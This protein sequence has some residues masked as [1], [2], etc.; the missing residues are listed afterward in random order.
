MFYCSQWDKMM[1]KILMKKRSKPKILMITILCVAA[2]IAFPLSV[3][4]HT[5]GWIDSCEERYENN[6]RIYE[7]FN[8]DDNTLAFY[9]LF[10]ES[11]FSEYTPI[12][13]LCIVDDIVELADSIVALITDD[14]AK[15]KAISDW[16]SSNVWYDYD[17]FNSGA[18][19]V[20]SPFTSYTL[21]H[22]RTHCEGYSNLTVALLRALG[23]PARQIRGENLEMGHVWVA[24]FVDERWILIDPTWNSLNYFENGQYSSQRSAMDKFFDISLKELSESHTFLDWPEYYMI[25]G[26]IL[27]H[28]SDKTLYAEVFDRDTTIE[29]TIPES[30]RVLSYKY[31]H[32]LRLTSAAED[33]F[34]PFNSLERL[35]MSDNLIYLNTNIFMYSPLSTIIFSTNLEELGAYVFIGCENLVEVNLPESIN[36]IGKMAFA[37]TNIRKLII[38]NNIDTIDAGV[39]YDSNLHIAFIPPSVIFIK[40][41][42]FAEN[43]NLIIYGHAGSVAQDYANVNNIPFI[44]ANSILFIDDFV[45]NDG[46]ELLFS[47]LFNKGNTIEISIPEGIRTIGEGVFANTALEAVYIPRSVISIG[48]DAFKKTSDLIIYGHRN[49]YAQKYALA[50]GFEFIRATALH[51][52]YDRNLSIKTSI[53]Y[54]GV[55]IFVALAIMIISIFICKRVKKSKTK[56]KQN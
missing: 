8:S 33:D 43:P 11:L 14:Y 26:F 27:M 34:K 47:P 51:E 5:F 1:T 56:A 31:G 21:E 42:A 40:E 28:S 3:L 7:S 36:T 15:A 22:R 45:V 52:P 23:V 30:L 53:Y 2:C 13:K 35:I 39:F 19:S 54:L 9:S 50:N 29:I 41:D 37:N 24:A 16:V 49:S 17:L 32:K 48:N 18:G 6:L 12:D 46:N 10:P 44:N 20:R 4:A 38:P 25:D 55:I